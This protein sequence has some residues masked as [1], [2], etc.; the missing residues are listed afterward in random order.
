MVAVFHRNSHDLRNIVAIEQRHTF[1][2]CDNILFWHAAC[3][4]PLY[5]LSSDM[6]KEIEK[7]VTA[8]HRQSI[9]LIKQELGSH[10]PTKSSARFAVARSISKETPTDVDNCFFSI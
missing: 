2:I 3:L 5:I 6:Y 1:S 8:L 7:F 10:R 9:W 4:P